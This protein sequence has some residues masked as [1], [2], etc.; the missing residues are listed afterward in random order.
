[1]EVFYSSEDGVAFEDGVAVFGALF[2]PGGF[3]VLEADAFVVGVVAPV[4]PGAEF[5]GGA[6]EVEEFGFVFWKV[7]D[8]VVAAGVVIG[9]P[10]FVQVA[11]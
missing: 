11:E 3:G 4:S 5:C 10:F 9:V 8:V 2:V 6:H 7:F 1:M